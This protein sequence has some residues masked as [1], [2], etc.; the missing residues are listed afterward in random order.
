LKL[1]QKNPQ[2]PHHQHHRTTSTTATPSHQNPPKAVTLKNVQ[3][4]IDGRFFF[5]TTMQPTEAKDFY[6]ELGI[7]P[8]ASKHQ[9]KAAYRKLVFLHHPDR[10]NHQSLNSSMSSSASLDDDDLNAIDEDDDDQANQEN[11]NQNHLNLNRQRPKKST[12]PA[13]AASTTATMSPASTK[14]HQTMFTLIAQA[15]DVLSDPVQRSRYDLKHGFV[16][17]THSSVSSYHQGQKEQALK[18][19]ELM[20]VT[21]KSKRKAEKAA[22]GIIITSAK[23]GA[24]NSFVDKGRSISRSSSGNTMDVKVQLQCM[25]EASTLYI[26]DGQSKTITCRGVYNPSFNLSDNSSSS[27]RRQRRQGTRL[28]VRYEFH[29]K[30]H[31]VVVEDCQELKIPMRK[32][33]VPSNQISKKSRRSSGEHKDTPPPSSTNVSNSNAKPSNDSS[34]ARQIVAVTLITTVAAGLLAL[35]LVKRNKR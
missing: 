10:R 29:G 22:N 28:C 21:Y 23:Y 11:H 25:V 35:L 9:I 18:E 32:H 8:S 19:L 6:A 5:G 24:I 33:Q 20:A 13:V 16:A 15:Y 12:A 26:E 4:Q 31:Q 30:H 34:T 17:T 7:S 1:L 3:L 2:Q 14:H 27:R